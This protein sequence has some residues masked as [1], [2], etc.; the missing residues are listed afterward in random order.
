MKKLKLKKPTRMTLVLIAL[1]LLCVTIYSAIA[2]GLASQIGKPPS[3][4]HGITADD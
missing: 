3:V 2:I 1:S 4:E